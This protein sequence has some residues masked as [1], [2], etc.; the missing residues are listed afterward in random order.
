MFNTY[1]K[2]IMKDFLEVIGVLVQQAK[3]LPTAQN[4]V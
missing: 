1:K 3:F 4:L 2:K